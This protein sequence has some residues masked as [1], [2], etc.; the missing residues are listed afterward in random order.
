MS[1]NAN[2]MPLI[3]PEASWI[4]LADQRMACSMPGSVRSRS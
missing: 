2:T 4:G 1:E 3:A